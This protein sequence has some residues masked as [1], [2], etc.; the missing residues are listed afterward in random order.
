MAWLSVLRSSDP[1]VPAGARLSLPAAGLSLGGNRSSLF[2]GPPGEAGMFARVVPAPG[3][4]VVEP[5]TA[6]H[7]LHVNGVR[8]AVRALGQGDVF[9]TQRFVFRYLEADWPGA[10]DRSREASLGDDETGWAVY[11]DWLKEQGA[12]QVRLLERPADVDEHARWVWPLATHLQDGAVDAIFER[13]LLHGLRIR[14]P[15]LTPAALVRCLGE[16]DAETRALRHL[17]WVTFPFLE[18]VTLPQKL[19]SAARALLE[20]RAPSLETLHLGAS[21]RWTEGVIDPSVWRALS[22][23]FPRLSTP[24]NAL[25]SPTVSARLVA[26]GTAPDRLVA[27][28]PMEL[29]AGDSFA[30][31]Q[32]ADG[33]FVIDEGPP[34]LRED[35]V[36]LSQGADGWRVLAP[37]GRPNVPLP[38]LNGRPLAFFRL[39]PGDVI[40]LGPGVALRFERE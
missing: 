5:A 7:G 8:A 21:P 6:G 24:T 2:Q 40:E 4:F 23:A 34:R 20:L 19:N 12:Q 3:G 15:W 26:C 22:R 14:D 13:G 16:V 1:A 17:A 27:S 32:S 38:R 11:G 31:R 30:F 36:R 29:R 28:F 10:F 25:L 35:A 18:G 37:E 39:A 9:G 33:R